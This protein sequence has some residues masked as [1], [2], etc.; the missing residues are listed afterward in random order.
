MKQLVQPL[1]QGLALQLSLAQQSET[2]RAIARQMAE[3]R[4]NALVSPRATA[5]R[6]FTHTWKSGID[7]FDANM[8]EAQREVDAAL[9]SR[10]Q[11]TSIT[12]VGALAK[13]LPAI[14]ANVTE[15]QLTPYSRKLE[16]ELREA[17]ET[18]QT[19]YPALRI[20]STGNVSIVVRKDQDALLQAGAGVALAGAGAGIAIAAAGAASASA[21]AAAA[22]TTATVATAVPAAASGLAALWGSLGTLLGLVPAATT[23]AAAP[24]AVAAP[25]AG[26][27]WFV[28]AGPVGWAIAGLGVLTIPLVW[29]KQKLKTKEQLAQAVKEQVRSLF[30]HIQ[31]DRIPALRKM[32]TSILEKSRIQLESEIQHCDEAIRKCDKPTSAAQIAAWRDL[33]AKFQATALPEQF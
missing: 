17:C 25:V 26:L 27:S 24:V 7:E 30:K 11:S 32:G 9:Q 16:R 22:A 28:I 3:E 29:R 12:G 18:L 19:S 15:E 33:D 5:E 8:A 21:A 10:I 20:D 1:R 2:E 23:V 13:E 31:S 4:K 14:I 6:I